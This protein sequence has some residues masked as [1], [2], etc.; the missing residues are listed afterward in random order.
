MMRRNRRG[1][2]ARSVARGGDGDP[3]GVAS[4]L[5]HDVS[6]VEPLE[7]RLLFAGTLGVNGEANAEPRVTL[8]ANLSGATG[9]ATSG[10]TGPGT[11]TNDTPTP[12]PTPTPTATVLV[13]DAAV[14]E[15]D[16]GLRPLI[17]TVARSGDASESASVDY[18]TTD[19][20]A[21]ADLDYQPV[22]GTLNFLPDELTKTVTVQVIGDTEVEPTELFYLNLADPVNLTI[23]RDV[24]YAAI[25][26]DD[27][28]IPTPTQTPTPTP[29]GPEPSPT[30]TPMDLWVNSLAKAEG[31]SGQTAFTF[32]VKMNRPSTSTV[33][34]HYSTQNVTAAR[35]EDYVAK[36]G[37][38]TFAP[39]ETSKTVTVLVNGD[40]KVEGDERFFLNLFDA[41]GAF[42]AVGTGEGKILNDDAPT[43]T[44]TP[45]PHPG[46][47]IAVNDESDIEGNTGL[48]PITF[49]VWLDRASTQ[50]VSV[51]FATANG[52][53]IA[54]SDYNA[55]SGTITFAPGQTHKTVTVYIR[56]DRL[57]ESDETF[58][59]NLS[60][61]MKA[62]IARG[63]GKGLIKN[64]D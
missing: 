24:G 10:A 13:S 55:A 1:G 2:G 7:G 33:K 61:P 43:P 53:A 60:S 16:A 44:P 9:A 42:I 47:S 23:A 19:G 58:F 59:V 50:T 49:K 63:Q 35:G 27:F 32:S 56:G 40:T 46:V 62:V 3:A 17:F 20:T 64:D 5:A 51:H 29:V 39:G 37:T 6:S 26:T 11:I 12:T 45:T 31:N 8:S 30:P 15:G 36:A 22:S 21:T 25:I 28:A 41:S 48:R 14:I 38:L 57:K 18:Y 4:E 54:G 52:T 34:V